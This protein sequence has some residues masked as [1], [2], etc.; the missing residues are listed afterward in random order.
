MVEIELKSN[1]SLTHRYPVI[2]GLNPAM[3]LIRDPS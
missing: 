1:H 3:V 2:A